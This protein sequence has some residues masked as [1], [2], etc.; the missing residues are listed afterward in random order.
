MR[1]GS[2]RGGTVNRTASLPIKV[3]ALLLMAV[4][5]SSSSH[6]T[7]TTAKTRDVGD[8]TTYVKAEPRA[9]QP[10]NNGN[11]P[12]DAM[13]PGKETPPPTVAPPPDDPCLICDEGAT[14]FE[15]VVIPTMEDETTCGDM[16][17]YASSLESDSAE[18]GSIRLVETVCC[19]QSV[20]PTM[21]PSVNPTEIPTDNPTVTPTQNPTENPTISPTSDPSDSPSSSPT[22][23]SMPSSAPIPYARADRVDAR[24]VP[25]DELDEGHLIAATALYYNQSTWE[26]YGTNIIETMNYAV[27]AREEKTSALALGYADAESWDC[28]QNHYE[29]YKWIDLGVQYVQ[30]RQWWEEL[31]WD[32]YSWNKYEDPPATDGKDWYDLSDDER[33]AA[34]QLCYSRRTWDSYESLSGEHPMEKPD[35]RFTDWYAV[36]DAVRDAA[37]DGL[38]Y[39]PLSWNVL[40]LDIVETRGWDDL[41][42]YEMEAA[43][44]IGFAKITWDCWQ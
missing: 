37:G 4:L 35:F 5:V 18:C 9:L 26:A 23:S 38:K 40:G 16:I 15:D 22:V 2:S 3:V 28:W 34:S 36:D 11:N 31:G 1:G 6:A 29:N 33:Y 42:S 43:T 44:A 19:F 41:T 17:L 32:I 8:G 12:D 30:A 20:S 21:P 39:S 24:Y 10:D 25:W 13:Q 7:S 27:L 14:V